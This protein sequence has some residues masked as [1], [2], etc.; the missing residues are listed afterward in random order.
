[1]RERVF[2]PFVTGRPE[3]TGLGLAIVNEIARANGGKVR[4]LHKS[5]G[6][7]AFELELPWRPS[8]RRRSNRSTLTEL[9]YERKNGRAPAVMFCR[10]RSV[11]LG[12][13]GKPTVKPWVR[14]TG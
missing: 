12:P 2:E 4:L 13:T 14:S 5:G 8:G 11:Q 3:G 6:G 7:S 1:L 10:S 9:K